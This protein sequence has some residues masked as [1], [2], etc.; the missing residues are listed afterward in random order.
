MI[1]ILSLLVI[2]LDFLT[3]GFL[4]WRLFDKKATLWGSARLIY[5]WIALIV[6]YH[7]VIYIISMC[8]ADPDI[9]I[10]QLL[11]PVVVLYIL[12]PL[13][14]AIIHYRGGRL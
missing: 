11:H 13:L 8:S 3:M 5:G 7:C 10:F 2:L 6:A 9:L 4:I 12:N 14:I 1:D